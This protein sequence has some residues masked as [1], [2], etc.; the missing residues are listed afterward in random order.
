ME[1]DNDYLNISESN[2]TTPKYSTTDLN[3]VIGLRAHNFFETVIDEKICCIE[4]VNNNKIFIKYEL[5]W[6]IEDVS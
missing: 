5:Y 1:D 6:T 3:D 2:I 4:L